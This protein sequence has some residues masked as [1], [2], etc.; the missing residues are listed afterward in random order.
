MYLN[1]S[2]MCIVPYKKSNQVLI[3]LFLLL[4]LQAGTPAHEI[5]HALGLIHEHTRY[6]RDEHININPHAISESSL[7]NFV[8]TQNTIVPG[9]VPYDLSS[10]MHYSPTVSNTDRYIRIIRLSV[11]S[12]IY[13]MYFWCWWAIYRSKIGSIRFLSKLYDSSKHSKF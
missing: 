7:G 8:K 10:I 1:L 11:N 5:G 3:F 2:N 4:L 13:L 12:L 9:D 6:D